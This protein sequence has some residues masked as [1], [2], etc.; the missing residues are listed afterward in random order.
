M[1]PV[2]PAR[3]LHCVA[4]RC[5]AQ[6]R[7]H[8][9]AGCPL[10]VSATFWGGWS[11]ESNG[12]GRSAAAS[13]LCINCLNS[14]VGSTVAD[15]EMLWESGKMEK[16]GFRGKFEFG[17]VSLSFPWAG[18]AGLQCILLC[19]TT[20]AQALNGEQRHAGGVRWAYGIGSL[21]ER[22]SATCMTKSGTKSWEVTPN[23]GPNPRKCGS[24][25]LS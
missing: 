19:S 13:L 10:Q 21:R 15:S 16:L 3:D 8:P 4:L 9:A 5:V 17:K 7:H 11:R 2:H 18:E 6:R 23:P 22:H 1:A 12:W 24:R 25:R 20:D 14:L